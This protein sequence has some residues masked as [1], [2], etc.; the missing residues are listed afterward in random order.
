MRR[1]L[2][3]S[4]NIIAA[5]KV[6]PPQLHTGLVVHYVKTSNLF[7]AAAFRVAVEYK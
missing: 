7:V 4:N 3:T 2:R 1:T 5:R 6:L